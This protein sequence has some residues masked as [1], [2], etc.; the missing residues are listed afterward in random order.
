MCATKSR[1]DIS[2][3]ANWCAKSHKQS[4]I[5]QKHDYCEVIMYETYNLDLMYNTAYTRIYKKTMSYIK[6]YWYLW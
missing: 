6:N 5:H 4:M 3:M 2:D 1:R